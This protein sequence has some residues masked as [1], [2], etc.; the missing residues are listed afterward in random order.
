M[1]LV[2][3]VGADE[4]GGTAVEYALI[5]ALIA[6]F[7]IAALTAMGVSLDGMFNNADLLDALTP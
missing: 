6:V 1:R 3:G 2:R 5:I 4:S 7:L